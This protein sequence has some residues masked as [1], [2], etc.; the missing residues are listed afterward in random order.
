MKVLITHRVIIALRWQIPF[1]SNKIFLNFTKTIGFYK[2][3]IS[4][5]LKIQQFLLYIIVA[6]LV[7]SCGYVEDEPVKDSRLLIV[8]D[9]TSGCKIDTERIGKMFEEKIDDQLECVESSLE[10]F[11]FVRSVNPEVLTETDIK[12]FVLKYF[13][14]TQD[15]VE[16]LSL[17]F[18]LNTLLLKDE[19]G[20]MKR[21]NIKPFF[22]LLIA[23]NRDGV[24]MLDIIEL[25]RD[26]R[27]KETFL[28][29][30]GRLERVV[31]RF[32]EAVLAIMDKS[33][34]RTQSINVEDLIL[35]ITKDLE[36][37]EVG[38]ELLNSLLFVKK[39]FLGGPRDFINT[40]EANRLFGLFPVFAMN[41]F[42]IFLLKEEI[43][44][45]EGEYYEYLAKNLER[46]KKHVYEHQ[47]EEYIL[48]VNDLDRIIDEF[49]TDQK[50]QDFMSFLVGDN[51]STAVKLKKIIRSFKRDLVGGNELQFTYRDV[52]I[53]L[54]FINVGIRSFEKVS[55]ITDIVDFIKDKDDAVKLQKKGE[56]IGLFEELGEKAKELIDGNQDLP[57]EMR[58]LKFIQS[59]ATD[60]DIFDM[61]P[62]LLSS[63][64]SIKV[65]TVGGSKE[66]VTVSEVL[67]ALE[68]VS[69][70]GK[71]YYD[72]QFLTDYYFNLSEKSKFEFFRDEI[73]VLKGLL[74]P[75]SDEQ[76]AITIADIDVIID[77]FLNE[78]DED[79]EKAEALKALVKNYKNNILRSNR[80]SLN[81][82][83]LKSSVEVI[84]TAY[85]AMVFIKF[86][87]ELKEQVDSGEV[88]K[89]IAKIKYT[90]E[91]AKITKDLM[92]ALES[93]YFLSEDILIHDFIDG[94]KETTILYDIDVDL[95]L[96]GMN[97]KSIFLGGE[98]S[99]LKKGEV[100]YVTT[101]STQISS[102]LFDTT[103]NKL[104][105]I[106]PKKE[107][108]ALFLEIL[109]NTREIMPRVYDKK[110]YT[111]LKSALD[112]GDKLVLNLNENS[113][114]PKPVEDLLMPSKL[115]R[116]FVD[117][118]ERML[119]K[120]K[121]SRLSYPEPC[122]PDPENEGKFICSQDDPPNSEDIDIDITNINLNK[123]L[124][125]ADEAL[126]ALLFA[127]ITYDYY[128]ADG[129]IQS[130]EPVDLKPAPNLPGLEY[131]DS[132]NLVKLK[133]SFNH[134][135]KN[136][137][138]FRNEDNYSYYRRNI[139]RDR[140][141]FNSLVLWRAVLVH[142]LDGYG[143]EG[144]FN[145]PS[146][147]PTTH[148][149]LESHHLQNFLVGIKSVLQEL[150]LWT[151]NFKT[152]GQNILL[153]SDLFQNRST[154]DLKINLDEASE[155]IELLMTAATLSSELQEAIAARCNISVDEDEDISIPAQCVRD[156]F[157]SAMMGDL[158]LGKYFPK[159]LEYI[160]SISP[161]D[162]VGYIQGVE[163]FARDVPDLAMDWKIRD[164]TLVIGAMLNVESTFL[165]FDLSY[166]NTLD[167]GELKGALNVYNNAIVLLAD[168][169]GGSQKYAK[170]V[171]FFMIK[172]MKLPP[173][174]LEGK[175]RLFALD[176][177]FKLHFK[178]TKGKRLNIGALL[179]GLVIASGGKEPPKGQDKRF[180]K[181]STLET[182]DLII[183]DYS[184]AIA[185]EAGKSV[186]S[187]LDSLARGYQET[188]KFIGF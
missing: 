127:E 69:D 61:D 109:R 30:R 44:D 75:E 151:N 2:E 94:L 85:K 29:L 16:A 58:L 173:Q 36:E 57:R 65:A 155:F 90:Q 9:L 129:Q 73:E 93:P 55:K 54:A 78:T 156:N 123:L 104:D 48:S 122:Q 68:L 158:K 152:F 135:A 43:F 60:T 146:V 110:I 22:E 147:D 95:I 64:F 1:Q 33:V 188:K 137:K 182:L 7:A 106:E 120:V 171:F 23:V 76:N 50:P 174:T 170:T 42:D 148:P 136:F 66:I 150:G 59:L 142:I 79:K 166:D 117:I 49:L 159:L 102:L 181:E 115:K 19:P 161:E 119:D 20:Q 183:E 21:E 4:K 162:A 97:F 67:K 186:E 77:Q 46:L 53:S 52:E 38:R 88:N 89:G 5:M 62:Q 139:K 35:D 185:I 125:I 91:F 99:V 168:L 145:D 114:E 25:M 31:T 6:T 118:S 45:S 134:I 51:H 84:L 86:H 121:R 37:F 165:R 34:G 169:K 41:A 40:I 17:L 11:K 92:T 108:Y 167:F 101:V 164:F 39:L 179:H 144:A 187:L 107:R 103:F 72:L 98:N 138:F 126:Q 111:N 176:T 143:P 56:F 47:N 80:D 141:G 100:R 14:D 163:G 113:D 27:D 83:E 124:D 149:G 140:I 154:G 177:I 26:E 32:S 172:Y 105:E 13:D 70:F 130:P 15:T 128:E 180:Q 184:D 28:R 131:I 157:F 71:L 24:E 160:E 18:K 82:N 133:I 175:L 116:T 153:L 132:T 8:D 10:K 87:E 3:K 178:N 112:F 12:R 96:L 74:L 63:L 81:F